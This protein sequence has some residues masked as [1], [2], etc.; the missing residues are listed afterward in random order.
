MVYI[1]GICRG[2]YNGYM[3]WFIWGVQVV[4]SIAGTNHG[5]YSGYMP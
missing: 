1:G 5:L 2:L 3:S 4:F